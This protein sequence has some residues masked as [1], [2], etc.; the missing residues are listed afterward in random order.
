M[1]VDA[2]GMFVTQRERPE[3]ALSTPLALATAPLSL[4]APA[5]ETLHDAEL[6]LAEAEA[7]KSKY[8]ES[9]IRPERCLNQQMHGLANIFE[10]TS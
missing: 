6:I 2:G 4:V 9:G 10:S 1:V 3:L 5:M 7:S 8:S